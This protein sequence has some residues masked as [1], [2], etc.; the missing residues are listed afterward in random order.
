VKFKSRA[1]KEAKKQRQIRDI[2]DFHYKP[3]KFYCK[4]HK[5]E[6]VEY[7]CVLNE[8]FYCRLCLPRHDQHGDV[9][10][11]EAC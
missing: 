3:K 11:A 6:E 10:L 7:C 8:S 2:Q 4:T 1:V 5:S 9:V